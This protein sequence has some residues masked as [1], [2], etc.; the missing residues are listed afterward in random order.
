MITYCL[1]FLLK[2]RSVTSLFFFRSFKWLFLTF[3]K[4]AKPFYDV[5]GTRVISQKIKW[6][7][8]VAVI[9]EAALSITMAA[10]SMNM[11]AL[12]MNMAALS[13][14]M[15]ALSK[16]LV[17]LFITKFYYSAILK[18]YLPLCVSFVWDVPCAGFGS[19]QIIRARSWGW[20]NIGKATHKH[21]NKE[22]GH[23]LRF[24]RD[25]QCCPNHEHNLRITVNSRLTSGRA[26][27]TH[28]S[29]P[30]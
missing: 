23:I 9:I 4:H 28:S 6:F 10:L 30:Q 5:E 27:I 29:L 14:H 18:Y 26:S 22:W 1:I 24:H 13:M 12:S 16:Y 19:R 15:V 8:V 21:G 11:A 25:R 2:W 3:V 17:A 20:Q 7:I